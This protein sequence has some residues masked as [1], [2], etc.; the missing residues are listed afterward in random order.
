VDSS[1]DGGRELV[2]SELDAIYY[3]VSSVFGFPVKYIECTLC[4]FAH[5]DK[6]WFSVHAHRRHLCAGCGRQF[7]DSEASIGNPI[8]KS[9][10]MFGGEGRAIRMAPKRLDLRQKDYPGGIQIWGSN[11]AIVWTARRSEEEGIHIHAFADDDGETLI[12]DTFARVRI[13]G[14]D[15]DPTSVRAYM[16]QTALPHIVDRV[17]TMRC[18]QC[19]KGHFETGEDGFTPHDLHVCWGCGAEFRS[20]GRFRKTVGNPTV[21]LLAGLGA[22]GVRTPQVH[23][24]GLLPET[25]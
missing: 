18:P 12:D 24:T 17:V 14:I 21:E 20:P 25:L 2:I 9:R 7:R 3:M 23:R 15:V 1:T 4:G 16:A 10:E 5:L 11:P 22:K 6:D 13:D 19:A 8:A